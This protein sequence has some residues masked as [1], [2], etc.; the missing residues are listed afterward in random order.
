MKRTT[1]RFTT[2]DVQ[3]PKVV[4]TEQLDPSW[5]LSTNQNM[6]KVIDE[7]NS[8]KS[9]VQMFVENEY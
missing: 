3:S 1:A 4:C 7:T 5:M 8:F 2:E 9:L 6:T